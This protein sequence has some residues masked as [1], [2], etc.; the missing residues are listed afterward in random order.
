MKKDPT[1]AVG[2]S[3]RAIIGSLLKTVS[4]IT[5]LSAVLSAQEYRGRI[6]GVVTD[7]TGGVIAG[8]FVTLRNVNTGITS[9]RKA[10]ERGEYLFDLV[11]PGMY[12][13]G[14][15]MPGFAKFLQENVPLPAK[16][17]LTVNAQLRAGD[18]RETVSVT[19]EATQLQFSTSKLETTVEAKLAEQVPQLYRSPFVLATLDP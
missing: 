12:T 3:F 19:A 5:L 4:F 16:G 18:V 6:Q 10:S 7:S 2:T 11:E 1:V 9:Q 8:A 17:D 14:V 13:V 15:E